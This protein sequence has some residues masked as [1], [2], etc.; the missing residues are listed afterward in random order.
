MA[1]GPLTGEINIKYI[2]GLQN[3]LCVYYRV[4]VSIQQY[5]RQIVL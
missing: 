4:L 5:L 2:K 1:Q 3:K